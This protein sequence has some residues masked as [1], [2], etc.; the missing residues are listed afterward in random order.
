MPGVMKKIIFCLFSLFVMG[1]G[2]VISEGNQDDIIDDIPIEEYV[3]HDDFYYKSDGSVVD[4][5][6]CDSEYVI[7]LSSEDL[8][9]VEE[10][11]N[12]NGFTYVYGPLQIGR[13]VDFNS[14]SLGHCFYHLIWI[15]GDGDVDSIPD[16]FFLEKSYDV[17][18]KSLP[19]I[20]MT[21]QLLW[22]WD[23]EYASKGYDFLLQTALKYAEQ[24]NLELVGLSLQQARFNCT[25]NSV[26]NPIEIS[27]WFW[28][29]EGIHV[30]PC[31]WT[32]RDLWGD[33]VPRM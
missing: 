4:L 25:K 30:Y 12:D 17:T 29:C 11:L 22:N 32:E 20:Y 8:N 10:Y 13:L 6:V 5:E 28:E 1:C 33:P 2:D 18:D 19:R 26:G 24:L 27:N 3:M 15:Y 23:S 31:L 21:N 9:V 16:V 14:P 7:A